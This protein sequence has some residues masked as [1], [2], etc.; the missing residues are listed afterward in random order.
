MINIKSL[1]III[2]SFLLIHTSTVSVFGSNSKDN[3]PTIVIHDTIASPGELLLQIDALNFIGDNGNVAAITLRIEI[4]TFLIQFINIQNTTL[5]GSWLGNYNI[6]QNEITITYTAPFGTGSDINGKLLDLNLN[7][8]GGFQG[9][10]HFK[11][12]CEIS[13]VNLITIQNIVYEDGVINQ[14][15]AVGIVKQDTVVSNYNQLLE[16]P[17]MAEGVGYDM[18]DKVSLRMHYD[19]TQLEYDGYSESALSGIS[20]ADLN[21]ILNIEWEDLQ[22]PVNFTSI[23]TL[24]LLHFRFV[25]DSNTLV[26]YMPG[27]KVYNNSIIVS[28]DFFDGLVKARF[29]VELINNPDTSGTA[30][31]AGYYFIDD[32]VT[33]TA[34][35]NGGF[36][37]VNWTKGGTVVSND[38]IYTFVKQNSNDTLF[39]NYEANSYYLSVIISPTDGGEV[40]GAGN[41]M[42][43]EAVELIAIPAE[44]YTFEHWMFG[45]EIVSQ[46]SIYV[47]IMPNNNME[48]IAVFK[49]MSFNINVASNNI[50]FGTVQGG[51]EFNYG[52]TCVIIATPL[53]DF[54]FVVWTDEG[55]P[56]SNDSIYRFAV[57]TN[58][59]LIANFQYDL[60]CSGPVGL[61]VDNL[62]ETEAL[63][64]WFPSGNEPEWDVLWGELGF[65]TI[66][67]GEL[68]EALT[69][70][71]Y[72]LENLN[73]GTS[74][75]FYVRAVCTSQTH[76]SWSGPYTFNTWFVGIFYHNDDKVVV[77]PNPTTSKLNIMIKEIIPESVMFRIIN[78]VGMI[79]LDGSANNLNNFTI[80]MDQ[81][82]SGMYLIQLYFEN[83]VITKIFV[84]Q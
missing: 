78:S 63:L 64:N 57:Y 6:F 81:L 31:G 40:V 72:L 83:K 43:G 41:Y 69:E 30:L 8:F 7:Y 27:S 38:S 22:S 60:D 19:S 71:H 62:S 58:R 5:A 35:P 21:A 70:I 12:G 49:I 34:I 73:A 44:G 75:D 4:D 14:I 76:S 24:M 9:D 20:V 33:V 25:G 28:T 56:V 37:F 17:L 42:Y 67:G 65:D 45:D 79:K 46:D 32:L 50:D 68:V 18:V 53:P 61:Y 84:K 39:A 3:E 55:Q 23:D 66:N 1:V 15:P 11:A 26:E 10:L 29:V 54:K 77:F 80:N 59:D 47:F 16:M 52:D 82:A 13:N 74:Y 51:G 2:I 48:L 36:H